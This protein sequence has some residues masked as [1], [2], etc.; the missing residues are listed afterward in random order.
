VTG[1]VNKA[2]EAIGNV[3]MVRLYFYPP[4]PLDLVVALAE[5]EAADAVKEVLGRI[6]HEDFEVVRETRGLW[7]KFGG[8]FRGL[9]EWV[10]EYRGE[11]RMWN[12][13]KIVLEQLIELD[14]DRVLALVTMDCRTATGDVEIKQPS[15]AIYTFEDGRVRRLEEFITRP[16]VLEAA[17]LSPDDPRLAAPN[18]G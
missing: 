7:S 13:F 2:A 1:G 15:G 16:E 8:R 17:G 12:A 14:D 11:T 6:V 18:S 10:A 9:D 3:E 5:Q 4:E